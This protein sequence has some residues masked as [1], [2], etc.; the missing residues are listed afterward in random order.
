MIYFNG[1]VLMGRD[2]KIIFLTETAE[3]EYNDLSE[4]EKKKY[5]SLANHYFNRM[6]GN[7]MNEMMQKDQKS[8][9]HIIS[10]YTK[11]ALQLEN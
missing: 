1:E 6:K 7:L 11:D 2:C 5:Q 3:K 8:Y 9:N 10:Q 4:L